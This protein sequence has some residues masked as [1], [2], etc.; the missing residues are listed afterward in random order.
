[1]AQ[2]FQGRLVGIDR[3]GPL[4]RKRPDVIKAVE[5]VR[6]GMGK[7]YR[8]KLSDVGPDRL[9]PKFRPRINHE[10]GRL[11][12]LSFGTFYVERC[13]ISTIP[14]I[15][16][17]ADRAVTSYHGYPVGGPCS[18]EHDTH[19]MFVLDQMNLVNLE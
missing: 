17:G 13:P 6:M 18:K 14:G 10:G 5:M 3:K 8:I 1:M 11:V 12:C 9:Q 15:V 2:F 7:E 16:G 19:R 4:F